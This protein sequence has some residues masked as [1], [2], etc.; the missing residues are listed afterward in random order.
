MF[1]VLSI[2]YR[3]LI[4]SARTDQEIGTSAQSL[5]ARALA[6]HNRTT[7]ADAVGAARHEQA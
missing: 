3:L 1:I 2:V 5:G 7:S 6:P 4:E